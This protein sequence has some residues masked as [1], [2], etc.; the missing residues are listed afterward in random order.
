LLKVSLGLYLSTSVAVID[1][2]IDIF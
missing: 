2:L 1:I